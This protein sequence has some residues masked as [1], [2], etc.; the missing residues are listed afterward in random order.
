MIFMFTWKK[1]IDSI[2]II[3]AAILAI[4]VAQVLNLDFAISAGIVAILSVQPTK[5]ET[6]KTGVSRFVAFVFAI[7][8][9]FGCYLFFGFN[10]TGFFVYLVIFIFACQIFGW[11]SAMAMDSVL[12]SH[13]ISFGKF[14]VHELCNEMLLFVIGVGFGIVANLFLRKKVSYMEELRRNAD[15]QIRHILRR[16]SERICN[17]ELEDYDG[18]CFEKLDEAIFDAKLLAKENFNNEFF[19]KDTF[20]LKYIAMR[21]EQKEVLLEVYKCIIELKSV[22]STANLVSEFLL[23]VCEEFNKDNDVVSLLEEL[24]KLGLLM[25]EQPLPVK[26]EE[27]EDRALLFMILRRMEEFLLLKRDFFIEN[28]HSL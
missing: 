20:D 27:F 9:S 7:A 8:V 17:P 1:V 19:G 25:K 16:M 13:F 11:N 26:R 14:G 10:A 3:V 28:K 24:N 4:V 2:K 22:P 5:K 23:K 15:D 18:K 12:I 6:L 21:E